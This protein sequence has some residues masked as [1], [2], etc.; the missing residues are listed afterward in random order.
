MASFGLSTRR[1]IE[2]WS[3]PIWR[4][5]NLLVLQDETASTASI[6]KIALVFMFFLPAAA[7]MACGGGRVQLRLW[8]VFQFKT[9]LKILDEGVLPDVSL[10]RI[11]G[12]RG[13]LPDPPG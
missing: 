9:E 12:F 2:E 6:V 8:L 5:A 11:P 13:V 3:F 7:T 1:S 10:S 4:T